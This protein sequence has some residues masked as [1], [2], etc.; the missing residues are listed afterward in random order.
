MNN[1]AVDYPKLN[2]ALG[3][4]LGDKNLGG[5]ISAVLPTLLSLAGLILF[6]MLIFGG[7]TMLA[8]AANK[9]SQEKGKK[10]V[11]S[12]LI[13]F[14]VIFLAYWLAQILQVIFKINIV[15]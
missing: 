9:E 11:T 10:M 3:N 4:N 6:G 5:I 14:F 7:F 13:G 8:G 12:A 2:Q 1:Q 15:G